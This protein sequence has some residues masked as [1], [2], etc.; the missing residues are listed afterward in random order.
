MKKI[1]DLGVLVVLIS[2]ISCGNSSKK[3][4]ET[5]E[6][7]DSM[8]VLPSPGKVAP[9]GLSLGLIKSYEG[10]NEVEKNMLS[11]YAN[12]QKLL[13]NGRFNDVIKGVYSDAVNYYKKTDP[14]LSDKVIKEGMVNQLSEDLDMIKQLEKKG[15]KYE[16]AIPNLKRRVQYGDNI[17][18]VY[19]VAAN[20]YSE[21]LYT[22]FPQFEPTFAVSNDG[23]KS[24]S[25]W[26]MNE[27]TPN[28]LRMSYPDEVVNAVMGY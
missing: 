23:G 17:F 10:K 18:I 21:K 27:D 19:N 20:M 2:L 15:V 3:E 5:F 22:Y 16:Y 12:F 7:T 14:N 6:Y 9:E 28:I 26:S 1:I 25:F 24:W 4:I 8:I 11:Q 13:Y